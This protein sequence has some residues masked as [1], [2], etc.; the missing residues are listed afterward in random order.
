MEADAGDLLVVEPHVEQLPA[1]L[2]GKSRV[3]LVGLQE[4]LREADI[5]V[6]LVQHDQFRSMDR[7][8]LA[9]K[10]LID[11]VGVLR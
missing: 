7:R 10:I 8:M 2:V 11:T 4:A 1:S 6:L 9:E 5:V 3:C